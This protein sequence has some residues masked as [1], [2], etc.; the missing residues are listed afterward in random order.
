MPDGWGFDAQF[1]RGKSMLDE[2]WE[3]E[4][5]KDH[6]LGAETINVK[7]RPGAAPRGAAKDGVLLTS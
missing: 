2:M 7:V 4:L 5:V 6:L 1:K 3:H